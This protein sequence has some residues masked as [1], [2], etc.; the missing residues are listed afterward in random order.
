MKVE[1]LQMSSSYYRYDREWIA[2]IKEAKDI[3]LTPTQ[4][5]VFLKETKEKHVSSTYEK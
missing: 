3:G 5:K 1:S 2:L 4:I